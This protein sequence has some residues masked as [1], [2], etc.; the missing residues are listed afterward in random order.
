MENGGALIE[1]F[2]YV[3][4]KVVPEYNCGVVGTAVKVDVF[5]VQPFTFVFGTVGETALF[6][7]VA[8]HNKPVCGTVGFIRRLKAFVP[9]KDKGAHCLHICRSSTVKAAAKLKAVGGDG[10]IQLGHRLT[11][12]SGVTEGAPHT[13]PEQGFVVG[14]ANVPVNSGDAPGGADYFVIYLS[15]DG[16]EL[17]NYLAERLCDQLLVFGFM[18]LEPRFAVVYAVFGEKIYCFH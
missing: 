18:L 6:V 11:G 9:R 10:K 1:A 5:S 7:A 14:K 8:A 2:G 13:V 15:K 4:G 17:L 12:L 3:V 16:G